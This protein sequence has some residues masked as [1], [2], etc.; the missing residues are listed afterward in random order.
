MHHVGCTIRI[1]GMFLIK[2]VNWLMI[3]AERFV[4]SVTALKVVCPGTCN[5][6]QNRL[7]L[8]A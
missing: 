7:S 8:G 6:V 5:V 1:Y 4:F 2:D 3:R